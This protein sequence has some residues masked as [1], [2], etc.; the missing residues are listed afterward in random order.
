MNNQMS[1]AMGTGFESQ[2]GSCNEDFT[3]DILT[4]FLSQSARY[5]ELDT[6]AIEGNLIPSRASA[7]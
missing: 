7:N 5:L 4:R 6:V 1:P 3:R 2:R